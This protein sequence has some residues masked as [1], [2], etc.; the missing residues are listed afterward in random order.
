MK[1]SI[2]AQWVSEAMTWDSDKVRLQKRV[3]LFLSVLC[4]L[5]LII[6]VS[7][8]GALTFGLSQIK[9]PITLLLHEREDG[10]IAYVRV[11]D[12]RA[13]LPPSEAQIKSD[14]FQYVELREQYAFSNLRH[15][16]EHIQARSTTEVSLAYKNFLESTL[17]PKLGKKGTQTV[18]VHAVNLLSSQSAE[19]YFT[20][21]DSLH[22]KPHRQRVMLH[23]RYHSVDEKTALYYHN[24]LGFFVESYQ[25]SNLDL[26]EQPAQL[27]EQ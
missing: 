24:P 7:L 3:L 14:C 10:S 12:T 9:Q 13:A 18:M 4:G 17:Y 26:Y 22:K 19:V 21:T 16:F 20:V 15:Q 8:S 6:V 23:W 27:K 1:Q 25:V 11:A 2:K 5:L